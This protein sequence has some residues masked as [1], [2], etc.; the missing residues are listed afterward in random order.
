M[1]S[2]YGDQYKGSMIEYSTQLI[3]KRVYN[4]QGEVI[5]DGIEYLDEI[6]A[7]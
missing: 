6:P 5:L 3:M 7:L 2:H 4:G 1:W